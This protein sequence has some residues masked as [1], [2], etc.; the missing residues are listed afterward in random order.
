MPLPSDFVFSQHNLQDYLDCPRR[1]QLRHLER[2]A[3][4]A[5]QS[6]PILE[7]ERHMQLGELFHRLVQQHQLG[8]PV[9][10]LEESAG[11]D[12]NLQTWW[13]AYLRHPQTELPPL[14][15][16]EFTLAAQFAGF[17]LLAKYDLLAVDPGKRAVIVDWKTNRRRTPTARLR[18]R[19]QT[20]LYPFLL[21]LAGA[22][23]NGG[24]AWQ[25]DQ[26]EMIYW[27]TAEPDNP[28]VFP[29]SE[30][31]YRSDE[32]LLR[33]WIDAIVRSADQPMLMT[34]DQEHQCP[35]CNYRSFCERGQ[36]AGAWED[37]DGDVT[38]EGDLSSIDFDFHEIEEIEF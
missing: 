29:Y 8:L 14:R 25:P 35:L 10:T 1:F 2:M 22:Q 30:K 4:P 23:L 31:Q 36:R 27:F 19:V 5:V 7:Q 9:E 34:A 28:Q 15:K 16:P 32:K 33:A 13:Q 21:A 38:D 12:P 24:G 17:R 3:W 20:R 37:G 11:S 26:I 6:E 18:E